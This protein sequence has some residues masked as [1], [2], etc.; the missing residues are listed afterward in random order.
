MINSKKSLE[1]RNCSAYLS[2]QCVQTS[3]IKSGAGERRLPDS[4]RVMLLIASA[5]DMQQ[6]DSRAA[7]C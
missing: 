5:A 2:G 6:V 3:L 1:M 7:F 4:L